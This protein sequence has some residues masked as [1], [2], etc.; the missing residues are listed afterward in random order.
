MIKD[1]LKSIYYLIPISWRINIPIKIRKAMFSGDGDRYCPL[2]DSSFQAFN[3]GGE[4]VIRAEAEC[5]ICKSLERHRLIAL[6]LRDW[7]N[8][9]NAEGRLLH[10]APLPI[11]EN[12]FR[13]LKNIDYLSGDLFRKNVMVKMDITDIQYPDD[14]FE[15]IYCSHV[16]E[17]VPEDGKAMREFGR[18]LTEEGW[19]ILQVPLVNEQTT[20]EDPS[21]TSPEDR[22]KHFGQVDHVR[23]Y[24]ADYYDRLIDAGLKVLKIPSTVIAG[25]EEMCRKMS[26]DL[27]EEV[28][29]CTKAENKIFNKLSDRVAV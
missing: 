6:F 5:P 21:I 14:T 4:V 26:I 24:G 8:I 3:P 17:H 25:G 10:I 18:V 23:L 15:I 16:L 1:V 7:A 12:Y 11:F 28:Y 20:Y 9:E 29:F 22:L 19:A 2:C 27:D 13:S